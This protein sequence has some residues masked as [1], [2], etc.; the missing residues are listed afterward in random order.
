MDHA[1]GLRIVSLT[2]S[3][4]KYITTPIM[5]KTLTMPITL[6]SLAMIP[7]IR[8]VPNKAAKGARLHVKIAEEKMTLSMPAYIHVR[9]FSFFRTK[10]QQIIAT[11]PYTLP[12]ATGLRK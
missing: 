4:W 1:P 3:I 7:A 5:V 10:K 12:P 8:S 11:I 9:D 2:P 6:L